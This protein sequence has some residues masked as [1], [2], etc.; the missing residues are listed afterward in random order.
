MSNSF[1]ERLSILTDSEREFIYGL[2]KF[3]NLERKH[4]FDLEKIEED[5]VREK[6]HGINSKI[7]FI[8]QLAYFKF[9]HKFFQINFR[10]VAEDVENT[11][12]INY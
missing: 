7:Y 2:P 5:I 11:S 8:L 4:C 12:Q 1:H 6:L 9:S 3:T 10:E